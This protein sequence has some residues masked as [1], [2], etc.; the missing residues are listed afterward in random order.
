MLRV[1]HQKC[2][3]WCIPFNRTQVEGRGRQAAIERLYWGSGCSKR[4]GIKVQNPFD[5]ATYP[6]PPRPAARW[7]VSPARSLG[8]RLSHPADRDRLGPVD[9]QTSPDPQNRGA[10]AGLSAQARGPGATRHRKTPHLPPDPGP[11]VD[12]RRPDLGG[13]GPGRRPASSKTG[14]ATGWCSR[15]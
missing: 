8:K 9:R 1:L 10:D 3:F 13:A 6:P 5:D 12:H 4:I 11:D 15:P 7:P 14:T 2:L